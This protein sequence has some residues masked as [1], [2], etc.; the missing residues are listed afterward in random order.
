MFD[1][2]Y[3]PNLWGLAGHAAGFERFVA[4]DRVTK[5]Y[6]SIL[7]DTDLVVGT[8]EEVAI[9]AGTSDLPTALKTIRSF[10]DATIVL[11][12]GA[13]VRAT[14]PQAMVTGKQAMDAVGIGN[15]VQLVETEY[16]TCEGADA[17]VV[18]TEWNEYRNP[19]M[20]RLKGLMRGRFVF[21]GRNCLDPEAA[22]DAGLIYRG[23]GRQQ[24]GA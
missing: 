1:I 8:E 11:K 2:D 4:S 5:E 23:M 16:K 18:A 6:Q 12:R 20:A 22:A 15:Q 13:K 17:L 3:R 19:D 24:L 10:T 7:A 21:D 9:A 14:D